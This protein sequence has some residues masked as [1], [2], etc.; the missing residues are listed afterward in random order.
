LYIRVSITEG[1]TGA[2]HSKGLVATPEFEIGK[3][4]AVAKR[5][6]CFNLQNLI[7]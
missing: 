6:G 4:L 1:A 3:R 5:E 2:G 7:T